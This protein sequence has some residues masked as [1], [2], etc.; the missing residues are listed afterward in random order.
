MV[1][2][3]TMVSKV[4]LI[5][6]ANS[7][8]G[9]ATALLLAE[10]GYRVFGGTRG[11]EGEAAI[12]TA[13][14]QRGVN[15]EPV[16]LD[17]Q[18]PESVK[19]T[20]DAVLARAGRID[21]LV[22]NAGYGLVASVEEVTDEEFIRQFD[23]NVFG[24][25]RMVRAVVP[26]M[27]AAGGGV[28][29]NIGS[30]LGQMGL[31]LL[32][33][34]NASKYAVEG[35][36]D[37]LRFELG[38]FNIRVHTVAP[39]LFRTQFVSRGLAANARTTAADSPYAPIA[40]RLLPLVAQKINEGPDAAAVAHAVVHALEHPDAEARVPAGVEAVEVARRLRTLPP[41]EFENWV[42]EAFGLESH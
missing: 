19:Q 13:A 40:S 36:T 31:P 10:R 1:T 42:R 17:V 30:F 28:I 15:V 34:Y 41:A 8:M 24:V 12:R 2:K 14:T 18:R 25:L 7:G 35:I 38:P 11:A 37:S 27:R 23:V 4:A 5:T 20:V 22:N 29:V 32:T 26:S 6:G 39:G 21:A 16:E 3:E 9:L 33:H